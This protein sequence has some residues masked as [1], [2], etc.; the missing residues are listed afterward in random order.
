MQVRLGSLMLVLAVGCAG[1]RSGLRVDPNIASRLPIKDRGTELAAA[2][3]SIENATRSLRVM[4]EE[5]RELATEQF[6]ARTALIAQAQGQKGTRTD[7]DLSSL[8]VRVLQSK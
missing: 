8:K 5:L 4:N 7:V 6:E 1:Q 2:E 3:Y